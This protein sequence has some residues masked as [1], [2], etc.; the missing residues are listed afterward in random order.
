MNYIFFYTFVVK[1]LGTLVDKYNQESLADQFLFFF[2]L[3]FF[4]EDKINIMLKSIDSSCMETMFYNSLIRH[5][6]GCYYNVICYNSTLFT[7]IHYCFLQ[8][9]SHTRSAISAKKSLE[10]ENKFRIALEN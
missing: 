10:L 5:G 8:I 7:I 2:F 6:L 9:K 1:L 3:F 4:S